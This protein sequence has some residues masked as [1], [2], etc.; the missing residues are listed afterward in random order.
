MADHSPGDDARHLTAESDWDAIAEWCGGVVGT[1]EGE[2]IVLTPMGG[3]RAGNWIVSTPGGPFSYAVYSDRDYRGFLALLAAKDRAAGAG[4]DR[5][6]NLAR[7][8]LAAMVAAGTGVSTE[9]LAVLA[10]AAVG[11]V[12]PEVGIEGAQVGRGSFGGPL[13]GVW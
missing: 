7:R 9:D 8:V 10:D 13:P 2:R 4:R 1:E 6:E 12:L 3:A 11:A 5:R